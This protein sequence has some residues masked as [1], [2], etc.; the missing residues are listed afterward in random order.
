MTRNT[1]VPI[2]DV[3]DFGHRLWIRF[4]GVRHFRHGV[5]RGERSCTCVLGS[6]DTIV[7]LAGTRE[8]HI[9]EDVVPNTEREP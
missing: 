2:P 8:F 7:N 4:R 5:H 6:G 3:L 1:E 9:P